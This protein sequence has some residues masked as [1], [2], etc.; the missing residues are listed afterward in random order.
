[1]YSTVN[2]KHVRPICPRPGNTK[3]KRQYGIP[4]KVNT[5][6][7]SICSVLGSTR[8]AP[9]LGQAT[10]RRDGKREEKKHDEDVQRT[11]IPKGEVH[12]VPSIA[13]TE[14]EGTRR[15]TF[16]FSS[17]QEVECASTPANCPKLTRQELFDELSAR[18]FCPKLAGMSHLM[19]A[20][21]GFCAE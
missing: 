3:N 16:I 20:Q 4:R 12:A 9:S 13:M 8:K 2:G 21:L 17:V 6:I 15:K 7:P 11:A 5:A 10:R 19:R 1:M 14:T 18:I